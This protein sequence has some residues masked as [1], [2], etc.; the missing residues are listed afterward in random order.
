MIGNHLIDYQKEKSTQ[1]FLL[2]DKPKD[3][4]LIL[5]SFRGTEP[6]DADD[7][8][9]DADY[10]WYEIPKV[11]KLHMGFLEA[12]GLGNR[13][14]TATFHYHLQNKSTKH[15]YSEAAEVKPSNANAHSE[16]SA[17]I[18]NKGIPPEKV[19]KTAYYMVRKSSRP[20]LKSTRM[21]NI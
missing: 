18:G 3:A 19:E 17:G 14:D 13:E 9:T 2:C 15:S 7:W 20:C 4:N 8:S 11:G 21:Q 10:S 16:G 6:F 12:L 1:V 5:I